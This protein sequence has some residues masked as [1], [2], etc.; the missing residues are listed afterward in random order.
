M[1]NHFWNRGYCVCFIGLD[2]NK[3]RKY[4]DYLF[5]IKTKAGIHLRAVGQNA[6]A[7]DAM[8]VNVYKVRYFWTFFGGLMAGAG[9]A[10]LTLNCVPFWLDGITAGR[11]WVACSG[12][13]CYVESLV[14]FNR[15]LFIWSN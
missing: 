8:G 5:Y 1:G 9:G 12:N 7:A 14:R 10:Y 11:G 15:G 3:I 2:E 6:Q 13:I 4:V